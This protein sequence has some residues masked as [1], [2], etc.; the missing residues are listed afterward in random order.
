MSCKERRHPLSLASSPRSPGAQASALVAAALALLLS[1]C[2][3]STPEARGASPAAA[4]SAIPVITQAAR[5]E[6]MGI[7]IEAVGTT[8]ANESVEITSKASNTITAIRFQEGEEV[9]RGSVLVEMDGLQAQGLA[10]RSRGL[11]RTQQESVRPQPR[12]AIAPGAVDGGSRAGR[13][14]AEGRRSTGRRSA[15]AARR[16]RDPRVVQGQDGLSARQRR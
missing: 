6:P 8:Q 2:T 10:R 9:E 12:F 7:E 4:A 1:A 15:S 13:R 3:Q 5:I 11:A 16:H 14:V